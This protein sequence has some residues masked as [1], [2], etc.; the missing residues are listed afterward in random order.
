MTVKEFA[1]VI[2]EGTKSLY[3]TIS[4]MLL[5][6]DLVDGAGREN[7]EYGMRAG[8]GDWLYGVMTCK[9]DPEKREEYEAEYGSLME[10]ALGCIPAPG[11]CVPN[12][13]GFIPI[14]EIADIKTLATWLLQFPSNGWEVV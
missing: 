9:V 14:D 5:I 11:T 8:N 3:N 2:S 13:M 10:Y 6:T 4:G 1:E 7:E 12:R